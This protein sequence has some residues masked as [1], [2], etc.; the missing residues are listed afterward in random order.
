MSVGELWVRPRGP[1]RLVIVDVENVA[2]GALRTPAMA[3][4]ARRVVDRAASVA[5][6]EQVIV[7][8][9]TKDGLFHAKRA[10]PKARVVVRLGQD[11]ADR[12]LLEVLGS[13]SVADRFGALSIVSG[14]G[15]FAEAASA[16]SGQGV[17]VTAFGWSEGMSKRLRLAAE[18]VIYLDDLQAREVVVAA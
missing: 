17:D 2:G 9:G 8:V 16:L 7:G 3:T 14:D 15:I 12:A 11:G 18:R 5:P 10:W 13:E 6:G 4:W 1:R